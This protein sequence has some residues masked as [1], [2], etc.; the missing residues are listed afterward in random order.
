M[1]RTEQTIVQHF[2]LKALKEDVQKQFSTCDICQRTKK[3]L[4]KSGTLLEKEVEAEPWETLC[5]DMVG[6]YTIKRRG[7]E[8]PTL[9]CVTMIDPATGWFKMKEVKK[10]SFYCSHSR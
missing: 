10:R 3:T 1:T 6:P 5:V 2:W 8:A 4:T 9:W 7:A